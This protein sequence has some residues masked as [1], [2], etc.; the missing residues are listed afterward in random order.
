MTKKKVD[1]A[2][3]EEAAAPTEEAEAAKAAMID[4][5]VSEVVG[6]VADAA[7][8]R[9]MRRLEVPFAAATLLH[10]VSRALQLCFVE[11]DEGDDVANDP[12]WEADVEPLPAPIDTWA[13]GVVPIK[14]RRSVERDDAVSVAA[15]S[16]RSFGMGG[17]SSRR[18][19]KGEA[20]AA[21]AGSSQ[22]H[23][24]VREPEVR[25]PDAP[26]ETDWSAAFISGSDPMAEEAGEPSEAEQQALLLFEQR[27]AKRRDRQLRMLKEQHKRE[28]RD[29]KVAKQ[30]R[31]KN[32]TFTDQGD[33]I[34][35]KPI[36]AGKLPRSAP[37]K[38]EFDA[39]GKLDVK[40]S[41]VAKR[42]SVSPSRRGERT[43]SAASG[44]GS[45]RGRNGGPGGFFVGSQSVQPSLMNTIKLTAGV[46]VAEGGQEREGPQAGRDPAHMSRAA[47]LAMQ[48]EMVL[49]SGEG[50]EDEEEDELGGGRASPSFGDATEGLAA[51]SPSASMS[52]R[53]QSRQ[54]SRGASRGAS[55]Q[56]MPDVDPLDG[57]EYRER[58]RTA[59]STLAW[60]DENEILTGASDWGVNQPRGDVAIPAVPEKP[61]SRQRQ[62]IHGTRPPPRARPGD[63]PPGQRKGKRGF[64]PSVP[65]AKGAA[66]GR[67]VATAKGSLPV[68]KSNAYGTLAMSK[69]ARSLL[70]VDRR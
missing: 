38:V 67:D 69:S 4:S 49:Q 17:R 63:S 18:G 68:Q 20:D 34:V 48:D 41:P 32:V 65:G 2:P 52:P 23:I 13:T 55:R 3:T 25:P 53:A 19:R 57:A 5:I 45:G 8:E 31:G 61:N 27:V 44:R 50:E 16:V 29:S 33:I 37:L 21:S 28:E 22:A 40:T 11:R 62:L 35:V 60:E 66:A 12:S 6:S 43:S 51:R 39:E 42:A 10:D 15:E 7:V 46:D 59:G 26:P 47:F 24:I 14:A 1:P 64:L 56:G 36:A 30:Y 9:R 54:Q 70:E 58:A